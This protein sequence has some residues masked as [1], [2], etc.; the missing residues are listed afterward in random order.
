MNAAL[1]AVEAI[2]T[3]AQKNLSMLLMACGTDEQHDTV[4]AEYVQARKDYIQC[5]NASFHENDP[6]LIALESQAQQSAQQLSKIQAQLGNIAKAIDV[7]T[8]AVTYGS[9]IAAKVIA[10]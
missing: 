10:G 5:L 9:K 6:A 4:I 8:T 1:A 7:L 3:E 2:Y